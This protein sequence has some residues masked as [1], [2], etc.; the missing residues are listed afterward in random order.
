MSW[1]WCFYINIPFGVITGLFITIFFKDLKHQVKTEPGVLNK[2]KRMD[3]I[4]ILMFIPAIISILLSLQWGGT[5]YGWANA[6]IIALF[7]LFGVFGSLWCAVQ[8]WKQDEATVPPRL[9]KNRNV[10][11]AVIHAMFLGGSFFVFGYYVS[12]LT[13]EPIASTDSLSSQSG[14]KPSK[15]SQ[16]QNQASTTSPWSSQ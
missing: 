4:G 10:L 15:K 14:S 2:V 8:F 9:L 5:K 11:G 7:V 3:P 6:R 12:T 16:P 1:R 13:R